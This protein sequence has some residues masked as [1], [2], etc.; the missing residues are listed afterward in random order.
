MDTV[1]NLKAQLE[2]ERRNSNNLIARLATDLKE[3]IQLGRA[4]AAYRNVLLT[5]QVRNQLDQDL[6]DK[7]RQ[8]DEQYLSIVLDEN[9]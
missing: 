2:A 1:A 9:D 4:A 5:A 6:T 8:V 3:A 7:F